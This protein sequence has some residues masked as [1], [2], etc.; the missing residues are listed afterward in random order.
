LTDTGIRH[1]SRSLYSLEN[2]LDHLLLLFEENPEQE[3]GIKRDIAI[4][5]LSVWHTLII[6]DNMET[7]SDG[8]ILAFIQNLPPESKARVLLTSRTRT[9]GWELPIAVT[10]MTAQETNEFI[11]LIG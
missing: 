2:L 10:E 11:E 6:L 9:G 7:V 1:F 5:L 8:R 4:E 3:L